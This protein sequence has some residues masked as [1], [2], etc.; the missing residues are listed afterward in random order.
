MKEVNRFLQI[1]RVNGFVFLKGSSM[2]MWL[3][4]LR[5]CQP[6]TVLS[7]A[8]ETLYEACEWDVWVLEGLWFVWSFCFPGNNSFVC[9]VPL[10]VLV[11]T[12][13]LHPVEVSLLQN[14]WGEALKG[15]CVLQAGRCCSCSVCLPAC[16]VGRPDMGNWSLPGFGSRGMF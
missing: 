9:P 3:G 12:C 11:G 7:R 4:G 15:L 2:I 16:S 14:I 8:M 10:Q 1:S 5:W 13:S 6:T